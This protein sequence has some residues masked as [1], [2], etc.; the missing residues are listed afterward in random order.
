MKSSATG[1]KLLVA[2]P[3]APPDPVIANPAAPTTGPDA[4]IT[5]E[6]SVPLFAG[7]GAGGSV[8]PSLNVIVWFAPFAT[9]CCEPSVEPK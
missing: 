7:A 3:A 8:A 9:I 4:A 6:R 1:V 2:P 5:S